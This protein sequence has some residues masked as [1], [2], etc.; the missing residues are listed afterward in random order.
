MN[1]IHKVHTNLLISV[2]DKYPSTCTWER[3]V[4]KLGT[5]REFYHTVYTL[6]TEIKHSTSYDLINIFSE[7][8]IKEFWRTKRNGGGVIVLF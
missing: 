5:A 2:Q 4:F 1:Y 3:N 7:K 8:K 6:L